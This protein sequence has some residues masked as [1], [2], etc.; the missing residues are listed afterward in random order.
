MPETPGDPELPP[1][2]ATDG[3]AAPGLDLTPRRAESRHGRR[4][5]TARR[6]ISLLVVAAAVGG[7]TFAL[8]RLVTD[9]SLFFLNTD[10]AVER[11]D[12]LAGQRFRM[13][14]TPVAHSVLATQ[15]DFEQAVAFTVSFEGVAADVVH[16]GSPPD[17]FTPGVPVVLEGRWVEGRPPDLAEFACGVNDGYYFASD[18]MLVKHDNEYRDTYPDRLEAA[19]TGGTAAGC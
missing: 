14:G 19:G 1:A 10:E 9:A 12:E 2:G 11:R 13:Q 18:H 16:V 5:P 17:L 4:P 7:I 6:I 8:V 3:D 15:L